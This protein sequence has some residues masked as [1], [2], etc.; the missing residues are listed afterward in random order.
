[1]DFIKCIWDSDYAAHVTLKVKD[2]PEEGVTLEE[3]KPLIYEIREKSNSMIIIADLAGVPLISIDRF[4]MIVKIVKEV[5]DY[6]KEDGLLR[7]IQFVNTGF[8]FRALYNPLSIAIPKDFRDIVV[9]L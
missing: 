3:L 9:F 7:Q 2:Y 5:V 6:T 1:M 4:R 8:I